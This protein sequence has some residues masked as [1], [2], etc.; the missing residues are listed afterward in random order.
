MKKH[1]NILGLYLGNTPFIVLTEYDLIKDAFKSESLAARPSFPFLEDTRPG[2][3]L[4]NKE[5]NGN[6][7]GGSFAN[8]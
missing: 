3:G 5:I 7:S 2:S 1:G 8:T 6:I 4:M